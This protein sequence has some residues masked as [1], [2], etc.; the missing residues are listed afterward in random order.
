MA[1]AEDPVSPMDPNVNRNNNQ[2]EDKLADTQLYH[3]MVGSLMYAALGTCPDLA[4]CVASLSRHNQNPLQ[5]HLTAAKC[6]LRY[7]KQTTHFSLHY[8]CLA[9]GNG[10]PLGFT[11][12]DWAGN[13]ATRKS[14]G[15]FI[16][17]G[18][19]GATNEI[20]KPANGPVVWQ[21]KLQSV[22]A[23]STLEAE[24][25]ACSDVTR[26]ALWLQRLHREISRHLVSGGPLTSSTV[27]LPVTI[28]ELSC[29]SKPV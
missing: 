25:I 14:M 8:P 17:F 22:V 16:F 5:M 19:G 1:L 9:N 20:G 15:R 12:S 18:P 4:F 27:R 11:D 3:S 29:S 6:A 24:Y 26:E 23:L 7:L 10:P 28:R 21:A 13:Q 2:C